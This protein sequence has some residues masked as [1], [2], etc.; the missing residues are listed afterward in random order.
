MHN[1][2]GVCLLRGTSWGFIV[3]NLIN[4]HKYI[5]SVLQTTFID[6]CITNSQNTVHNLNICWLKV[7]Y[8]IPYTKIQFVHVSHR[9]PKCDFIRDTSW[10]MLYGEITLVNTQNVSA[11]KI[12]D[13]SSIQRA[14]TKYGFRIQ[15]LALVVMI[16][17]VWLNA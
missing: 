5:N 17:E 13:S 3:K 4:K 15:F 16:H 9:E 8:I 12:V 1:R 11:T 6:R 10:L 7:T 14:E 2:D